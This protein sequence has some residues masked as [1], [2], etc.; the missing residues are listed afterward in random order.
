ME[1]HE[2]GYVPD[3][4]AQMNITLSKSPGSSTFETQDKPDYGYH[5]RTPD[6]QHFVAGS[7]NVHNKTVV[8]RHHNQLRNSD[9]SY[10][11]REL[12]EDCEISY[13]MSLEDVR[14]ALI[15]AFGYPAK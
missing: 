5:F 7:L 9:M 1:N 14:K 2:P 11:E 13:G 12:P 3:Y 15:R 4:I 6:Q 10:S 8:I